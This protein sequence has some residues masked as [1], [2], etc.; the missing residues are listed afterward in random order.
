METAL[1]TAGLNF[2]F[3][4]AP[5]KTSLGMNQFSE[6]LETL[7]SLNIKSRAKFLEDLQNV[8]KDSFVMEEH[9]PR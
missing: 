9:Y 8:E 4:S 7:P 1:T 2:L 6:P 5:R 3:T